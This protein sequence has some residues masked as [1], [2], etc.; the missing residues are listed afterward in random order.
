MR[1]SSNRFV[2]SCVRA[3]V[4]VLLAAAWPRAH[5]SRSEAVAYFSVGRTVLETQRLRSILP[6][7]GYPPPHAAS[8]GFGG[9]GYGRLGRRLV[10][11][12]GFGGGGSH[13]RKHFRTSTGFG[14]GHMLTGYAAYDSDRWRVYPFAGIGGGGQ[15]FGVRPAKRKPTPAEQAMLPAGG[16]GGPAVHAGW[17][18]EYRMRLFPQGGLLIGLQV[19]WLLAPV[20]LPWFVRGFGEVRLPMPRA[21]RPYVNLII[22][23]F[24]E[25]R[26]DGG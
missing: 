16:T 22:G 12:A 7:F 10:G 15:G 13:R 8:I 21:A 25:S 20:R 4:N 1:T 17:A 23:A 5:G 6:A 18:A 3:L 2:V 26:T 14:G 24:V 19:G 9:G 11:G